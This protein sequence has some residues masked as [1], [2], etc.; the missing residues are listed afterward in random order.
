MCKLSI[1]ILSLDVLTLSPYTEILSCCCVLVDCTRG[2]CEQ[3]INLLQRLRKYQ[4]PWRIVLTKCDLLEPGQI[5][6]CMVAVVETLTTA[7]IFDPHPNAIT[8]TDATVPSESSL[9]SQ[10]FS[11]ITP[12]SSSTGAGVQAFWHE[13]L[14]VARETSVSS[15]LKLATRDEA[16]FD[17]ESVGQ[18]ESN[19]A[20]R[21]HRMADV[22]RKLA[23]MGQRDKM[24]KQLRGG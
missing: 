8:T 15:V 4:R 17:G 14:R 19:F 21:E 1:H 2:L 5:E 12:I 9:I 18:L 11:L 23:F 22:A 24:K 16:A 20:V 13:L 7:G 10:R 6:M 3:D